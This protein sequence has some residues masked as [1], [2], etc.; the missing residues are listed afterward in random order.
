MTHPPVRTLEALDALDEADMA[1]GYFD[2]WDE[3]VEP[4]GNRSAAYHHGWRVAQMDAGRLP[5]DDGHRALVAAYLARERARQSRMV[6]G[7]KGHG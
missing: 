7:A 5:I 4:G 6:P 2:G 1:Q 3:P